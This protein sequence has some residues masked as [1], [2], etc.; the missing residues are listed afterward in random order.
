MTKFWFLIQDLWDKPEKGILNQL[1]VPF[2]FLFL[3]ARTMALINGNEMS[4]L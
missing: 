3:C 4:N 2:S 1:R